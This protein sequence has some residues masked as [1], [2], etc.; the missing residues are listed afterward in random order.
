MYKDNTRCCEPKQTDCNLLF[1]ITATYILLL[2]RSIL[3]LENRRSV[4]SDTFLI[5]FISGASNWHKIKKGNYRAER[6]FTGTVPAAVGLSEASWLIWSQFLRSTELHHWDSLGLSWRASLGKP[7]SYH[8]TAVHWHTW[9]SPMG[10]KKDH[11]FSITQHSSCSNSCL[12]GK[13]ALH[14]SLPEVMQDSKAQS[15]TFC[16]RLPLR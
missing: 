10:D 8:S 13:A 9:T 7:L 14:T 3:S 15:T 16:Q 1:Q 12:H 11:T 5:A 4:T 2:I 6:D